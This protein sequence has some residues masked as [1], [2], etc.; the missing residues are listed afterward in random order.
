MIIDSR[1]IMFSAEAIREAV[2]TYRDLFPAKQPPGLV[3]PIVIRSSDP[4][5]LGVKVQAIGST[6]YREVEMD[7]NEIAAMLI[8][9][10]RKIKIPLP[11]TANKSFEVEGENIAL[12]VSKALMMQ[13][14]AGT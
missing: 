3:G 8:V 6:T 9:F 11:R 7:E 10:C 5:I 4:L 1:H 12:V 14:A 13:R 2:K